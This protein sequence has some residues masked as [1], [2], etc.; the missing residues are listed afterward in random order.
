MFSHLKV[1][2]LTIYMQLGM[3]FF[4][5]H[6]GHGHSHGGHGHSHQ[7]HGHNHSHTDHSHEGCRNKDV[8]LQNMSPTK[9]DND[10]VRNTQRAQ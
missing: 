9:D 4:H 5:G 10:P 1:E 2:I 3:Y 8:E 7:D 6:A